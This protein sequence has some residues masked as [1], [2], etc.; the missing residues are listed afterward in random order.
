MSTSRSAQILTGNVGD[1]RWHAE[2]DV[3][4]FLI[5]A[6]RRLREQYHSASLGNLPDPLDE[7]VFIQLSIRTRD[8]T[9]M[10]TYEQLRRALG[11]DWDA[12]SPF[13]KGRTRRVDGWRNGPGQT[14]SPDRADCGHQA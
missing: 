2:R 13:R 12:S 1:D 10:R 5:E 6:D 3:S 8:G 7:L 4:S 11:G 9:Y 14:E